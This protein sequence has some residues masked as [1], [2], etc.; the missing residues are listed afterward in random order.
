M[1][2]SM[3][4]CVV[5]KWPLVYDKVEISREKENKYSTYMYIYTYM[6]NAFNV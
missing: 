4:Q 5:P 3:E 1:P 2:R 6:W